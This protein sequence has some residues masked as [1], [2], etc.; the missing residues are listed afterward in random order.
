MYP[1]RG[2]IVLLLVLLTGGCV[3]GVSPTGMDGMAVPVAVPVSAVF[4]G[5]ADEEV[6]LE[7]AVVTGRHAET[8]DILGRSRTAIDGTADG[9]TLE[10]DVQVPTDGSVSVVVEV[11]LVGVAGALESV[12][13]SGRS[14]PVVVRAG[15]DTRE[16]QGI[17]LYR[18]PVSNLDVEGVEVLGGEPR[19]LEGDTV[20]LDVSLQGGGEGARPFFRVLDPEILQVT[21][22]GRVR[23]LAPGSGSVVVEA[24]PVADTVP[25]SVDPFPL[26]SSGAL[27]SFGSAVSDGAGRLV[28]ALGDAEAAAVLA[29][30]LDALSSALARQDA[31]D[32]RIALEAARSGLAAYPASGVEDAVHLDL[33]GLAIDVLVAGLEQSRSESS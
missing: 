25:V 14:R 12:E 13:W 26:P 17:A 9:W 6:V 7:A 8:G 33:I 3:D 30:A 24:G 27:S 10:V 22:S 18:G 23:G 5:V 31:A 32:I 29:S 1:L 21:R 16:I 4:S 11:E 28:P 19:L 2:S 15:I 20:R